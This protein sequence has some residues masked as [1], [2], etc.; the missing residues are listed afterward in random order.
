V[1]HD[2][3]CDVPPQAKADREDNPF[4]G[5]RLCEDWRGRRYL[6]VWTS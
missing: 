3:E 5:H 6:Q 2:P 4:A 1:Q